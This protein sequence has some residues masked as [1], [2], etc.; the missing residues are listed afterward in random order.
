MWSFK[1]NFKQHKLGLIIKLVQ[2]KTKFG[3]EE[4]NVPFTWL[5]FQDMKDSKSNITSEKIELRKKENHN[6]VNETRDTMI[7]IPW[8]GQA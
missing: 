5:F 6:K 4:E 3:W 2:T 8:F 1:N 7:F